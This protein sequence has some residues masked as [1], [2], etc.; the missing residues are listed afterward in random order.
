MALAK[1]AQTRPV[2]RHSASRLVNQRRYR[3]STAHQVPRA[4]AGD[5]LKLVTTAPRAFQLAEDARNRRER[6]ALSKHAF[7][8]D[9]TLVNIALDAVPRIATRVSFRISGILSI[10]CQT[11]MVLPTPALRVE[12]ASFRL[13]LTSLTV[14]CKC[15]FHFSSVPP[16]RLRYESVLRSGRAL[17]TKIARKTQAAH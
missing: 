7:S 4:A 11:L 2:L 9:A 3:K 5:L 17:T 1:R 14:L 10:A 12:L 16:P 13:G 6:H 8:Y 15:R